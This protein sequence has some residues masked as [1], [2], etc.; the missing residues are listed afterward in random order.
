M[1]T[2]DRNRKLKRALA[3]HFGPGKVR[4]WG[5][6]GTSYGWVTVEVAMPAE[7]MERR[8]ALEAEVW[9][10]IRENQIDIGTYGYDDPGSDYGHGST[11]HI[12]FVG[13]RHAA[14]ATAG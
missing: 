2:A 11:I 12:N 7:T 10:V 8:R 3:H 6:R 13:Q 9:K 5:S 1:S 4:V 14:T